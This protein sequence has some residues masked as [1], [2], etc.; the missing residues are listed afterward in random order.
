MT[1]REGDSRQAEAVSIDVSEI[2]YEEL[3]ENSI[4]FMTATSAPLEDGS[5]P[6]VDIS[7]RVDKVAK[8]GNKP[9]VSVEYNGP[10]NEGES[11]GF[12]DLHKKGFATVSFGKGIK[13]FLG[14]SGELV[15]PADCR[16]PLHDGVLKPN[17]RRD[18]ALE[19]TE[20]GK[21]SAMYALHKVGAITMG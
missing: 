7:F 6:Q 19:V 10:I 4:I 20:P 8:V 13:F 16:H 17:S 11:F 2:F 12:Y 18:V 5:T 21:E 1:T 3:E 14:V 9:I 15:R